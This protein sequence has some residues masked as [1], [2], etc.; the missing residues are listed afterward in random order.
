MSI[1]RL[2]ERIRRTKNP[3]MIDL[4]IDSKVIPACVSSQVE[5]PIDAY[6]LFAQ[7]IMEALRGTVPAVR[8]QFNAFALLG[9]DGLLALETVIKRAQKLGFY[10]LLDVPEALSADRAEQTA[11]LLL[12]EESAYQFDGLIVSSYIGSDG[13]KPYAKRV[14]KTGKSLFVIIRTPNKSASELQDL[15][16]GSRLVHVAMADVVNNL[17]TPLP[18]R[19]GFSQIGAAA[20]A[21]SADSLRTL[22]GKYKNLFL[23]VDGYDSP[24]ANAKNCSH[25]FDGLGHGAIVCAGRSVT[26][27]WLDADGSEMEYVSLTVDAAERMKKNLTKYVSVL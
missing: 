3:S 9:A 1:D 18:A 25:A 17:A 16:T 4:T 26:G 19:C 6:L 2:Q 11:S 12:D 7:N 21:T 22:R 23:L 13:L 10:V 8:F 14:K 15:L 5:T 24:S 20:S 27:A